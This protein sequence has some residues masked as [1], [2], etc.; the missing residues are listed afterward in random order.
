[1]GELAAPPTSATEGDCWLVSASPTGAWTGHAGQIA[2]MQGGNWLYITPRDGM[3]MLDRST[4]QDRRYVGAW[5]QPASPS[6]PTGGTVVDIEARSAF[7]ELVASL[8]QAGI[9]PS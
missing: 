3:R 9:F 1:M 4:G 7:A 8:R 2:A 6:L 5:Q